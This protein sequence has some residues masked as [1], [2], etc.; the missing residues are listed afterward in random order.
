MN[1]V[2]TDALVLATLNLLVTIVNFIVLFEEVMDA[3]DWNTD[4]PCDFDTMTLGDLIAYF[5]C[6]D[7]RS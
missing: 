6:E 2:D 4:Q 3:Y 5:E 7:K 1:E